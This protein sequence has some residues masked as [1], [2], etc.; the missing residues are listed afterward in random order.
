MAV[1][2]LE[3][4]WRDLANLV[5]DPTV[6]E[7]VD[8]DREPFAEAVGAL[9]RVSGPSPWPSRCATGD[10]L[11]APT[12]SWDSACSCPPSTHRAPAPGRVISPWPGTRVAGPRLSSRPG[13]I[14]IAS[15]RTQDHQA[16][17]R[18]RRT[19]GPGACRDRRVAPTWPVPSPRSRPGLI[20]QAAFEHRIELSSSWLIGN[21]WVE[22][23]AVRAAG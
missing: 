17:R 18:P 23:E 5:V 4:C 20:P 13:A 8:V 1:G 15:R 2:G 9:G 12:S 7:P 22:I 21:R 16:S 11:P 19:P 6:V 10:P 14:S 3:L